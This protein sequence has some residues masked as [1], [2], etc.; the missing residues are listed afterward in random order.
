MSHSKRIGETVFHYDGDYGGCVE[1]QRSGTQVLVPFKHLKTFIVEYVRIEK[2]RQL[3]D[4]SDD[5]ILF[6]HPT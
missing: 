1:I 5:N 2:I 3:E 6:N 4:A